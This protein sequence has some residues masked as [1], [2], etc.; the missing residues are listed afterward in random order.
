[1][2][3]AMGDPV[4]MATVTAMGADMEATTVDMVLATVMGMEATTADTG[5]AME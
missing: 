5:T 1:M 4:D 2:I 3:T